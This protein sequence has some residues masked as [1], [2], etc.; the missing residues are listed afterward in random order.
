[1]KKNFLIISFFVGKGIFIFCSFSPHKGQNI[2]AHRNAVGLGIPLNNALK[3]QYKIRELL[4]TLFFANFALKN[5][6]LASNF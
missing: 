4:K 6:G 5:K 1:L 3:G 2:P